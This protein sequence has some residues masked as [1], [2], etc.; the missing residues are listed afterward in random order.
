M[1]TFRFTL[2]V[3]LLALAAGCGS[4]SPSSP[5]TI[6][7]SPSPTPTPSPA[8]NNAVTIVTGA[9]FKGSGAFAPNPITVA[10][11]TMVTWTNTDA[12]AHT[13]TSD[14][15]AF[16]SGIIPAGGSFNFTFQTR[17]TFP[18]HCSIH[19]GMVGSVVVQ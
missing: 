13:S 10:A 4:S 16:D 18:Y 11:G 12:I 15:K 19:P 14:T 17:G 3:G 8:S 5:T 1:N 7:P 6:N 9:E 2:A